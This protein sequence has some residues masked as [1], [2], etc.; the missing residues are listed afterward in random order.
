MTR[1]QQRTDET[2]TRILEAAEKCFAQ[3]GYDGTGVAEICQA[4]NLSKG[5]VYHHFAS[6]HE[7]FM[8]LLNRWLAG[9]DEH[10][11]RL[12]EQHTLVPEEIL[13]LS[14]VFTSIIQVANQRF[15]LFLEFW[16][17]AARDVQTWE[18]AMQPYRRYRDFF[19]GLI[20]R[21]IK[22]GTLR[23][24]DPQAVARIVMAVAM[25]LFIQGWIEPGADWEQVTRTGIK[26]LID[27]LQIGS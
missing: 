25:G 9:L 1:Q 2:R 4:A 14:G 16:S 3:H 10:L 17:R 20:D 11:A 12:S 13:S 21:G 22:E 7:I 27:G 19:A 6:K 23:P 8:E 15:Q 24:N 5:A 26:L 18:V